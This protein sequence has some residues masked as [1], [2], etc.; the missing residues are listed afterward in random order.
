MGLL[1]NDGDFFRDL[2][3]SHLSERDSLPED[4]SPLRNQEA[5]EDL[6]KGGLP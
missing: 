5:V 1:G 4:F 3:P 2:W 6:E